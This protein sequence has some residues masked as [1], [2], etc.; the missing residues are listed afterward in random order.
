[1][2]M[3]INILL[4]LVV[5]ISLFTDLINH[6]ILNVIVIPGAILGFII[7]VDYTGWQGFLFSGKGLLVGIGLLLIPF[8]MGGLGAGD[9]KLLGAIG[10][11]KG[12]EFVFNTFLGTALAGGIIAVI[13][14]LTRKKFLSSIKKIGAGLYIIIIGKDLSALK[15][16]QQYNESSGYFPY[17]LAISAGTLAAFLLR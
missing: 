12:T 14:F 15:N 13:V 9:V 16:L 1:M 7:N 10:A 17:G 4:A 2:A 8:I 11:I 5:M 6:K 3:L